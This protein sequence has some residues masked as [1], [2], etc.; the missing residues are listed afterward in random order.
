MASSPR[1]NVHEGTESRVG[2]LAAFWRG[3]TT[4][5]IPKNVSDM[6]ITPQRRCVGA[7]GRISDGRIS[8]RGRFPPKDL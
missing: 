5:L 4:V 2:A 3:V 6:K 1:G 7:L 8:Y